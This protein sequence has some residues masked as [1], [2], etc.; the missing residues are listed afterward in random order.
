MI[1]ALPWIGLGW[2]AGLATLVLL[3]A[4]LSAATLRSATRLANA[5]ATGGTGIRV[6]AGLRRAY[7]AVLWVSCVYYYL[8]IPVVLVGVVALLAG[9]LLLFAKLGRIPVKLV[10]GLALLGLVTIWAVLKSLWASVVPGRDEDPGTRTDPATHPRLTKLIRKVAARVR[11][12]PVDTLF[13]TPGTEI[14][15]FERGSMVRALAGRSERCLILGIGVLDGMTQG[16]LKAILAHE[17]GHFVNEDTAGGGFSLAVRRALV[18]MGRTLAE[19]GAATWYN[20]AWWF[21]NGF[22]RVFLRVSQGASRLQEVLADRRAALAYG[23]RNFTRGLEHA[24]AQS[25]R[26][27]DHAQRTLREVVEGGQPLANLYRFEPA[28]RK[29]PLSKP[30]H[31]LIEEALA[32]EP[33]PYDSHPRPKDR[34]AWVVR[35]A[36]PP[37]PD[38]DLPA[39]ELFDRR[40]VLERTMTDQVRRNVAEQ[41]GVRIPAGPPLETQRP[42]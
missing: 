5:G 34:I 28:L 31:V 24:I 10:L 25:I 37:E 20:P 19:G 2:L 12:R 17:Y 4:L 14:A 33:S 6:S 21:V 27:D 15:V 40:E 1:R 35:I 42:A 7:A 22:H 36:A 26:F 23:G 16:E 30:V 39:W 3:G 13:L 8:S 32:A 41:H 11:T 38:D 9:V 18:A 29:V